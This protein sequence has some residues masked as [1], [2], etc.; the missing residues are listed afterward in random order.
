MVVF[1]ATTTDPA[2]AS[3]DDAAAVTATTSCVVEPASGDRGTLELSWLDS[4]DGLAVNGLYARTPDIDGLQ[5]RM[6]AILAFSGQSWSWSTEPNDVDAYAEVE[7]GLTVPDGAFMSAHQADWLSDLSVAIVLL[8]S[9][10]TEIL[11]QSAPSLRVAWDSIGPVLLSSDQ[12]AELSLGG[13]WADSAITAV[14]D[15]TQAGDDDFI[16]Q[17]GWGE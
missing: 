17:Y 13:A 10:G 5:L 15:A 2:L 9:H 12:A 7:L 3:D 16:I 1:L 4:V 11:R 6:D 14:G 8:D